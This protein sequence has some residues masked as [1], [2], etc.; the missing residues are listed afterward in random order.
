MSIYGRYELIDPTKNHRKFWHIVYDQSKQVCI[1]T[2][3]RIGNRSPEPKEYTV[4]EAQKKIQQKL[5]KGYEK[6]DGYTEKI[7]CQSIHFIK[8][9]CSG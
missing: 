5:K 9:F 6:V 8:E 2:W 4:A 1:A 7:G 3:G